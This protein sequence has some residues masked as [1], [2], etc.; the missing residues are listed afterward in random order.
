MGSCG[1]QWRRGQ[2]LNA[3]AVPLAAAA[4]GRGAQAVGGTATTW[5][6]VRQSKPG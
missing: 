4:H 2:Q 5:D 6:A 1:G 3:Y